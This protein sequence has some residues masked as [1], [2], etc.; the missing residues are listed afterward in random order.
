MAAVVQHLSE[1]L[2]DDAILTNGAGNYSV[3]LH[4]FYQYR[5]GRTELTSTCGVMGYGLPAAVA[6]ALR[7]TDRSAVCVADDACFLMSTQ[8]LS[9]AAVCGAPLTVVVVNNRIVRTFRLV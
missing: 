6:D 5:A 3:W 2:P 4:R 7:P 8:E 9:T 1:S